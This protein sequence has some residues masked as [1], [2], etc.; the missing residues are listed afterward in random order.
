MGMTKN[1]LSEMP[2]TVQL[3]AKWAWSWFRDLRGGEKMQFIVSTLGYIVKLDFLDGYR[4]YLAGA[5]AIIMGIALVVLAAAGDPRGS[6]E[7][8]VSA[9][10]A[11]LAIIGGGGKIDK[12]IETVSPSKGGIR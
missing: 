8:G 5:G 1:P 9:I 6:I 11:G 10:L 4:T 2:W 12:L 7:Q 3:A